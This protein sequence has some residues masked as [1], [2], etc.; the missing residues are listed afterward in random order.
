MTEAGLSGNDT[1]S[2]WYKDAVFYEL[3][4]RAF[5]DSNGDFQGLIGK[6]DYLRD[7]GVTVIWLLPFFPSPLLDDGYDIADYTS[8]HPV[9][10]TL[11]DFQTVLHEAHQ[12]GLRVIIELVL[13]HTSDQHPW[14]QW[15]CR[16]AAGS[17]EREWYVWSDSPDKY[18][19]ARVISQDY[20]GS[21]WACDPVTQAY[22]W[23]RFYAHQPDFNYENPAVREAMFD[24]V[25]D[26]WLEI[27]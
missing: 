14:F 8:V 16:A 13:N 20:D 6:L 17:P 12:R 7:L 4:V 2:T 3:H 15:A 21:N 23:H 19:E 24:E 22:F 1:A 9:Y 26:F 10:G 25:V 5:A 11:E 27:G 18:G